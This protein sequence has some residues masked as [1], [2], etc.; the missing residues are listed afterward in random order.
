M[1]IRDI[2]D[3]IDNLPE[4]ATVFAQKYNGEC[5]PESEVIIL[6]M[7]D[8]EKQRPIKEIAKLK[9]PGKEYFLEIF[10]IKEVLD[11]WRANH[12]GIAPSIEAALESVIYYAAFDAY[13]ESF[14]G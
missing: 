6:E 1:N 9:A 11:G 4:D 3:N 13:P 5:I 10:I 2:I 12:D 7:T 14:Y 8:D